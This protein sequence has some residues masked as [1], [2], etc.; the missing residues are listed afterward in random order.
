[1]GIFETIGMAWV[2][3]TSALATVAIIYLAFIGLRVVLTK[4]DSQ[5]SEV[6]VEVKEM[7]K[8]AR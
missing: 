6:P 7:F 1:M 5:D 4:K 8:I 3:F 2:I